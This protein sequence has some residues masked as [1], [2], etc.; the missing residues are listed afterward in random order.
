MPRGD[1]TG[2]LGNGPMGRGHSN[3]QGMSVGRQGGI[4][5]F[6]GTNSARQGSL[7]EQATRLEEQAAKLRKTAKQISK[8]E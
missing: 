4:L 6:T 8:G 3:C 5:G 7:E 2:P 1:G